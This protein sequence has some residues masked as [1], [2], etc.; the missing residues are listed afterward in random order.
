MKS[1]ILWCLMFVVCFATLVF[2]TPTRAFVFSNLIAQLLVFLLSA[3]M[4]AWRNNRLSYVDFAWPAG[5]TAIGLQTLWFAEARTLP[6][7]LVAGIYL[8]IGLRMAVWAVHMYRPGVLTRDLPRYEYQRQRWQRA[9][10]RSE[11]FSVQYEIFV[12]GMANMSFLALPAYLIAADASAALSLWHLIWL[13]VWIAAYAFES[14][15]DWQKRR[16]AR[17]AT[18]RK[19]VCDVGL[20]RY[21]RHPN[22]FGQWVQWIALVA[23][24]LPSLWA[25]REDVHVLALLVL[26]LSLAWVIRLMYGTLVYYTGAVPAEHYSRLKRPAYAS[27][28]ATVNRFFPG[29]RRTVPAEPRPE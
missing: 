21:S 5:L 1:R 7:L 11:R 16:F 4:P 19:S 28:Q 6:V 9:G 15:A 18:D 23:M 13:I 29:P 14:T 27:Y 24:A 22:Y 10:F 20:W 26:A 25:L 12:Q 2:I 3:N 17:T 8:L